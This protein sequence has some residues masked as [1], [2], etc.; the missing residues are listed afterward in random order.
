MEK[1][2]VKYI[3][4]AL[5]SI[6]STDTTKINVPVEITREGIEGDFTVVVYPFTKFSKKSPEDTAKDL[7][8]FI[9]SKFEDIASYNI[10]KGF[11][12]IRMSPEYWI[13]RLN[14]LNYDIQ[15]PIS[16]NSQ[17]HTM[18]I[19][20]SSPNTNKPLHLGHIRN[21]LLG[22]SVSRICK[23]AGIKVIKVNLI[24]DRGIHICKSMLAWIKWGKNK[25]P[26]DSGLKGDK[27]VG[28][29]YVLFEKKYRSQISELIKS[30]KTEDE[31]KV[32]APLIVEAHEL[33]KKWE[34]GDKKVLQIWNMMNSW[35]YEGFEETYNSL[36]ISF[37]KVYY[38]SQTY[39]LGKD[40]VL[41]GLSEGKFV[42]DPDSS[43]W[44]DLTDLGMDRKILLRKDGTTVY[45]TQDIGTAMQR[46][47]DFNPDKMVYVVGNEQDY[48]F[49]VLKN[50][51]ACFDK[52]R[53]E[54]IEHLSYGMVELPE[55]KMKSREGTVV[56]AD[57]LIAE[58]V[59]S[60]AKI[61]EENGK[62]HELA[63]DEKQRIIKIIALGALKYYIL[64]VDPKKQ[65][66]F[67]PNESIDFN[68]NTGPFI[69]YT[70]AR[71]CSVLR[72]AEKMKIKFNGK[73]SAETNMVDQEIELISYL[74][75][76]NDVVVE[77]A[78]KF[79]PGMIANYVYSL[80]KE[81]N[82][83]YHEYSILKETDSKIMQLRLLLSR[84]VAQVIK[85]CMDLLGIDVPEVM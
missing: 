30:G 74:T 5:S 19:E 17:N 52:E 80:V 44:I 81:Y 59:D 35:V 61:S 54:K 36:S 26:Q 6:Y 62:I 1:S 40:I 28:D 29:F 72:N 22:D 39:L 38:E 8:V 16:Q 56:D 67:N 66:V 43:I 78:Q 21:N 83:Y 7:G 49:N 42:K 9:K 85:N 25:T 11:L 37:D 24:N 75:R 48:H 76:Y 68:G 84:N 51:I 58:M 64:K 31:A 13:N 14:Q 79:D 47:D 10:I 55:G 32:E 41:K 65:M 4:E 15:N 63:E 3:K 27:F 2:I 18:V 34:N 50:I 33:L 46:F 71:I 45:M 20:F 70:H 53:A 57:D 73:V 60:A 12:N 69:Q 77:A 23:A 82:Q